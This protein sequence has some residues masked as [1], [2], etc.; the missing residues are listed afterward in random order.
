VE[1]I[2]AGCPV[3][4]FAEGGILDSMTP[5]TAELYSTQTAEGLQQAIVQF[6]ARSFSEDE[7]RSRAAE[8]APERFLRGFDVILTRALYDWRDRLPAEAIGH[9]SP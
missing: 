7:L 2:A 8:F 3:V 9:V 1:A 4:A 6:E 5:Q